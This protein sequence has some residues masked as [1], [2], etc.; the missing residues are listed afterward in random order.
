MVYPHLPDPSYEL[1]RTISHSNLIYTSIEMKKKFLESLQTKFSN[2]HCE[3]R[4][5][6]W[7]LQS[8]QFI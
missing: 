4:K 5:Y 1:E 3:K 2:S 7:D 6:H 8:A